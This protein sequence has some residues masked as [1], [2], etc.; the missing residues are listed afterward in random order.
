LRV[1]FYS[2][3]SKKEQ[4]VTYES[5]NS[6]KPEV[7]SIGY[8]P[9]TSKLKAK[10]NYYSNIPSEYYGFDFNISPQNIAVLKVPTWGI[11]PEHTSTMQNYLQQ[12]MLK[13]EEEKIEKLVLD[14]R[15][16][17][18]GS[19]LWK[20]LLT[21]LINENLKPKI[22][23]V[24]KFR[25]KTL[26]YFP[27]CISFKNATSE[28]KITIKKYNTANPL[29]FMDQFSNDSY[30]DFLYCFHSTKAESGGFKGKLVLL[31]DEN[32]FSSNDQFVAA[33]KLISN[34]KI[35]TIGVPSNG[36]SGSGRV[37]RLNNSNLV[38]NYSI[39]SNWGANGKLLE[40]QGST[41]NIIINET[42]ASFLN[43]KVDLYMQEAAKYFGVKEILRG[44]N[45]VVVSTP[46]VVNS[47]I[48]TGKGL[49]KVT[50]TQLMTKKDSP[51]AN[52]TLDFDFIIIIKE[53]IDSLG[54]EQLAEFINNAG[55]NFI[56]KS[57]G[58]VIKLTQAN[59]AGT[60]SMGDG[61]WQGYLVKL[62]IK[63][64]SVLPQDSSLS[65]EPQS[66]DSGYSWS[67][68]RD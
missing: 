16:N 60:T 17:T 5:I 45:T 51:Y 36:G 29:D 63:Q 6:S 52:T 10:R 8:S 19:P 59:F 61:S 7:K 9:L 31:Y 54:K 38:V 48:S 28:Q 49:K 37:I 4:C 44:E 15:F 57:S 21:W 42:P 68:R 43:P 23:G 40:N 14:L 50:I 1:C 24:L 27:E 58:A 2:L 65:I 34:E 47:P 3:L 53:W 26:N 46:V 11:T 20:N 22:R 32:T 25:G 41:P 35:Q 56:L 30:G 39:F 33:T 67:V 66:N 62:N 18:G 12:V 55:F 13:I 64:R